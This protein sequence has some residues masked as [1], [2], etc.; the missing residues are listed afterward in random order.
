MHMRGVVR[1]NSQ[2]DL[3]LRPGGSA[4]AATELLKAIV[5]LLDASVNTRGASLAELAEALGVP[6]RTLQRRISQMDV[7]L[8]TLRD[9]RRHALACELVADGSMSLASIARLLGYSDPANFARAFRRW[10]NITAAEFRARYSRKGSRGR[11]DRTGP[12]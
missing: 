11:R 1:P 7:K 3:R 6:P 8:R 12:S 9:Q 4:L 10:E 5:R 2:R